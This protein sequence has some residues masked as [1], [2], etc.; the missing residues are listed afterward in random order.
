MWLWHRLCTSVPWTHPRQYV[1]CYEH[2]YAQRLTITLSA[3]NSIVLL[4]N[5][6]SFAIQA[7]LLLVIGAW[8][9]YGEWR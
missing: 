4:T 2:H 3:V 1:L 6:I 7:V 5:G 8:A 9:D